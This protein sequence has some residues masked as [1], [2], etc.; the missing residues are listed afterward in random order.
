[1]IDAN[2]IP[3]PLR[4]AQASAPC[5]HPTPQYVRWPL[6]DGRA[7]LARWCARCRTIVRAPGQ[8][9]PW[10][11]RAAVIAAG[12]DPDRL[13]VIGRNRDPAQLGLFGGGEGR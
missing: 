5:A 2:N 3:F 8:P 1:M 6:R 13:P 4:A 9:G 7:H 11:P 12:H 10:V